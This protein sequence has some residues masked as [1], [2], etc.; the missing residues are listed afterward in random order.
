MTEMTKTKNK[1]KNNRTKKK[2]Q[3]KNTMHVFEDTYIYTSIYKKRINKEHT[4]IY[5]FKRIKQEV[6][7][8]H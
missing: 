1:K 7:E 8:D 3:C 6:P 5:T 4:H 2:K